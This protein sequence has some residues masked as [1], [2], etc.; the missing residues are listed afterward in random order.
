MGFE[1]VDAEGN[2]HSRSE[3]G[4]ERGYKIGTYKI[5]YANGQ[6]RTV[7]YISDENGTRMTVSTNE[8]GTGPDAPADTVWNHEA[9]PAGIYEDRGPRPRTYKK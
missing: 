1:W 7:E 8:A 6:Y 2:S 4:D 3:S 5:T 9:P